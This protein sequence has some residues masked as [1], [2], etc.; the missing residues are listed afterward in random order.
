[1]HGNIRYC[2][3]SPEILGNVYK[4]KI[5]DILKSDKLKKWAKTEPVFC[6]NCSEKELCQ[7]GCMAAS[8]QMGY[9]LEREDSIVSIYGIKNK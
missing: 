9:G 6:K 2:N 5:S 8:Q 3:H 7:Y 1:M 4:N